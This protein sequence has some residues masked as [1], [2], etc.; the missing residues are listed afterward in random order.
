MV[1]NLSA[2]LLPVHAVASQEQYYF[3]RINQK[4]VDCL[5][6]KFSCQRFAF[7]DFSAICTHRTPGSHLTKAHSKSSKFNSHGIK[8]SGQQQIQR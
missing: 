4:G 6:V 2:V 3:I 8:P 7:I 1:V 5:G